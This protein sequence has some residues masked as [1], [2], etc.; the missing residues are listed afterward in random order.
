MT[1]LVTA[2]QIAQIR[3]MVNEPTDTTYSDVAL[4][5]TI[6]KYPLVD[7]MGQP[8]YIR[9][10]TA[11]F[12][13]IANTWWDP[14]YDLNAA[15]ADIWDEKAG[16]LAASFDFSADSS[17][18]N[19]SQAYEHATQRARLYRSRRSLTTTT[20]RPEPDDLSALA[21]GETDDDDYV[22]IG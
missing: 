2:A 7:I 20:M 9:S 1:T 11:P 3:R 21:Y 14:N 6:E 19:R 12:T 10:T 16:A 17:T 15:A 8:P 13:L 22:G 5:T 4:I 18:F